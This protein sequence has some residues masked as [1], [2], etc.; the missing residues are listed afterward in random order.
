VAA[1]HGMAYDM[2]AVQMN[3]MHITGNNFCVTVLPH[4]ENKRSQLDIQ[5]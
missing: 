1:C 2:Q 5:G 4:S 3:S